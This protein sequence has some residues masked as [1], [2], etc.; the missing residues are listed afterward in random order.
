MNTNYEIAMWLLLGLLTLC[1]LMGI[2]YLVLSARLYNRMNRMFGQRPVERRPRRIVVRGTGN[3]QGQSVPVRVIG[4]QHKK[5]VD[6]M[7][8]PDGADEPKKETLLYRNAQAETEVNELDFQTYTMAQ[9]GDMHGAKV[10][11][12]AALEKGVKKLGGDHW[13]IARMLNRLA[14][15]EMWD[16]EN[17]PAYT[18]LEAAAA[19]VSEWPEQCD[20]DAESIKRNLEY[21]RGRLGI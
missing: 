16:G 15:I 12:K 6:P 1:L 5:P 9:A 10:A 14:C 18:H 8:L 2:V 20:E 3:E 13:L 17:Y 21:L 7:D 4:P 19:I 11:G